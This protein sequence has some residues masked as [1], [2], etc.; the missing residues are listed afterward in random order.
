MIMV[1]VDQ[2]SKQ[3]HFSTLGPT[4]TAPQ[5]AELLVRDVIKLHGPS[6]QIISDR[7]P[8]FM[9]NFWRELFKLQEIM[10]ITSSGYHPQIDGQTKVLN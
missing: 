7:D 2:L 9:S 4:F 6:A 3:G 1:V 8:I 10:L 5:V